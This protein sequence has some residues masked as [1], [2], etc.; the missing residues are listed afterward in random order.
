MTK[1]IIKNNIFGKYDYITLWIDDDKYY[2]KPKSEISVEVFGNKIPIEYSLFFSKSKKK[3]FE[4]T[5][6]EDIFLNLNYNRYFILYCIGNLIVFLLL[7]SLM[8]LNIFYPSLRI[9]VPFI[10]SLYIIAFGYLWIFKGTNFI[11][12]V[13]I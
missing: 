5:Y 1:L 9:I 4:I 8:L 12:L 11:E 2:L 13:I 3:F 7:A 6:E 10:F